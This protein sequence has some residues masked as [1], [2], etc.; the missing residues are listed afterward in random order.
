MEEEWK[1]ISSHPE[2]QVSNYGK[3]KRFIPDKFNRELKILKMSK[4]RSGYFYVNLYNKQGKKKY[5]IHRLLL[6]AFKPI[7]NPELYQCNH[8][9]GN[10]QNNNINN[11]EWCT[12]SENIKH[13]YRIGLE[14]SR[15]GK[16][17]HMYGKHHTKEAKD[18]I[19]EG[20]KGE[21]H[22]RHKLTRKNIEE[23]K[24]LLQEKTLS[25]KEIGSIFGVSQV[26]IS[27]IK[28]NKTWKCLNKN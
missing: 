4:D 17:H 15:K 7:N 24:L 19:S 5:K 6:L 12:G 11:L 26:Q 3:V 9:D 10:K 23:I 14:L 25:Q 28:L 22:P 13:A 2:Y 1:V 20:I 18:K 27:M 21:N 8:I 16:D